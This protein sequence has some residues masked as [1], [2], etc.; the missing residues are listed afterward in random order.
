MFMRKNLLLMWFML[1][2]AGAGFCLSSNTLKG[3]VVNLEGKPLADVKVEVLDTAL[4]TLTGPDGSFVL[5]G[6]ELDSAFLL[7]THPDYL[8]H[9]L[10]VSVKRTAGQVLEVSLA[11]KNPMLMTIKQEISVTAE[12]DSIIDVNLPSHRTILPSSVLAELGTANITESVDKVPGVA[13]VGKGG[14]SMAPAIRGLAEHRVLLLVDGVRITSERRIGASASFVNLGDIDR[15]EINRGPYSVFH[16]SGAVGGIINIITKT[17][18]PG[19]PLRGTF[20]LGYNTARDERAGS[21]ALSGSLGKWAWMLGVNAKK[22]DDYTA[23]SGPIEWSRYSDHNV[24]FKLNRQDDASRF[25]I[26]GFHYQGTDIGKPSPSSRLKPRW[27]PH[28]GNTML[29]MGYN[30]S[31]LGFLDNLNASLFIMSS[32]LETQ[33]ENLNEATLSVSKRSHAEI[34]STNFG[35]KLRGSKALGS[36]HTLN[37]GFDYFGQ[38]DLNDRNIEWRFENSGA[39]LSRTEETSLQDA[40]RGNW[41]VYLDDKIR[42]SGSLTFNA[43]ARFDVI[44]TSNRDLTG[45][46]RSQS[47]D[48]VSLYLGSIYQMTPQLSLLANLGRSFRF[49]TVSELFYTG[50]TGRGT[51]FGNPDLEPETS[52]NVDIG[53]RYLHERFF[54]SLYGFSNT[55]SGMIQKF[56]GADTQ[57]YFYRNLTKGRITGV[58]GEF[59]ITLAK[60]V[61][62]FVNFH[63][64]VGKAVETDA[65]LNY[66]PPTRLT[67]WGKYSPGQFWV[68][69]KATWSS[70]VDEPGPLE[71]AIDG[72]VF[73]EAIFGYKF[74]PCFSV[75]AIAQNISDRTYRPSADESGVDAPGRGVVLRVKYSF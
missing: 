48:F 25:Y 12:A 49:P 34:K 32:A 65:A 37:V 57:E 39:V 30:R 31:D 36:A 19:S 64:M 11:A 23:P 6:L 59:Y 3:R 43:G 70:S 56:G 21:A 7:F 72:I 67:L 8:S 13:A 1:A 10:E 63:H 58:E 60:D 52:L 20:S 46:R 47:D 5:E 75:M 61:E 2:A 24:M 15:I 45:T 62:L 41:G 42:V 27:Y 26:S 38:G 51:V 50:L 73:L 53:L 33:G 14:Y 54:A 69:P 66:I 17:P 16:G 4:A 9:S 28:E 29:T 22:A 44:T 18:V 55:V 35:I 68:E 40:R 74:T 71:I